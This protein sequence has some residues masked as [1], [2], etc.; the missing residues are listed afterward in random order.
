[1]AANKTARVA[2]VLKRWYQV[3]RTE[4]LFAGRCHIGGRPEAALSTRA[5][6]EAVV[7]LEI[8]AQVH[9]ASKLFSSAAVTFL[10]PPN[11]CVALFDAA[12]P[13][14]MP[15]LN[16]RCVEA[17]VLTGLALGCRINRRSYFDRKHYFYADMPAG[18]QITQQR[19][20]VAERGVLR[21]PGEWH[22][23]ERNLGITCVQLEQD[24]GKSLHDAAEGLTLVDLNRA[25]VGLMEVVTE[26]ELTSGAEAAAAVQELQLILRTLGTCQGIMAEGHLRVDANVSIRKPGQPLG[27]RTEVKNLNSLRWLSRAVDFE[28]RRQIGLLETG[29]QI[30]NETRSFDVKLG[31]MPEPNLPS[32]VLMG[33]DERP[34][35][36]RQNRQGLV[37]VSAL[38]ALLPELPASR[39][40]R[41]IRNHDLRPDLVTTLVKEDGLMEYF[42]E[43][44]E[45]GKQDPK[46]V[47]NW[48]M[49]DLLGVL[50][51]CGLSV[52]QSPIKPRVLAELINLQI[53]G[54]ISSSVAK[55]VFTMMWKDNEVRSPVKIVAESGWSIICDPVQLEAACIDVI[56]KHPKQVELVRSGHAKVLNKFVGQ[57]QK[58]LDGR[59]DPAQVKKILENKLLPQTG[60]G[61]CS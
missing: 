3:G 28:I 31:F 25:G 39:R 43:V 22:G 55:K 45:V 1:M 52:S 42:E 14:T 56:A 18:Y 34:M 24:S 13:G 16:R 38:R 49:N 44:I 37:S 17:V 59:G 2:F 5:E 11:S 32:L 50:N 9:S 36:Q 46:I 8:H 41:L 26:P 6:W 35:N 23:R 48:V 19:V 33:D 12:L 47:I 29:G 53:D 58:L 21:V 54:I 7:G 10:A 51:E 60:D 20:P 61:H 57:V 40:S 30:V 27:V 15:V 4:T